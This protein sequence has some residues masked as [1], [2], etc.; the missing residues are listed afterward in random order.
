MLTFEIIY[1]LYTSAV[2]S[3]G[4]LYVSRPGCAA[5]VIKWLAVF[6]FLSFE[7]I[8]HFTNG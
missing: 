8:W 4:K 7:M 6:L 3:K 2:K 5:K 1:I